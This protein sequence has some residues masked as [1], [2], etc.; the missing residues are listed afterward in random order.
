[1]GYGCYVAQPETLEGVERDSGVEE[2]CFGRMWEGP[3][4]GREVFAVWLLESTGI[5]RSLPPNCASCYLP[6]HHQG[7]LVANLFFPRQRHLDLACHGA[8]TPL[9]EPR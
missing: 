3:A 9:S 5:S 2:W 1:M 8:V 4:L 7:T 6:R